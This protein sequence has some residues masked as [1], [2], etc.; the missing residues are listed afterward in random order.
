MSLLLVDL[1]CKNIKRSLLEK[2]EKLYKKGKTSEN[3]QVKVQIQGIGYK[4]EDTDF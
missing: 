3:E 1:P 2:E 4:R